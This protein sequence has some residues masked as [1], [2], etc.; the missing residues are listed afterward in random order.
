MLCVY[1]CSYWTSFAASGVPSG[2]E[3]PSWPAFTAG[4]QVTAVLDTGSI[5]TPVVGEKQAQ[6]DFWAQN[7]APAQLVWGPWAQ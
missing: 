7:P 3:L 5:L 1:C 6:C 2:N 4:N